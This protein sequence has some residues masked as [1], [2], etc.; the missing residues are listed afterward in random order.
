MLPFDINAVSAIL[1]L[2]L[3]FGG[4]AYLFFAGLMFWKLGR[5]S[6]AKSMK[7]LLFK[8]PILFIPFQ[9]ATWILWF[10]IQ[11]FNNSDLTG[12]W[13]AILVFAFYGLFIGYAYVAV[14]YL[15]YVLLIELGVIHEQM[16]AL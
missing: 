6:T 12:G 15:I 8:A 10:Y 13:D 5:L 14:V 11:K 9:V 2:S 7:R 1:M 4:L 16:D 3:A